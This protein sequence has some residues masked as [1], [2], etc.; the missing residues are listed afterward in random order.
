M[1][2][3]KVLQ[4]SKTSELELEDSDV[5]IL[6]RLGKELSGKKDFWGAPEKANESDYASVVQISS[7]SL[8]QSWEVTVVNSIGVLGL[9]KDSILV[10]PKIPLNHFLFIAS[11]SSLFGRIDAT[12]SQIGNNWNIIAVLFDSFVRQVER[13]LSGREFLDYV[14]TTELRSSPRG[15]ILITSTYEN[16]LR[17]KAQIACNFDDLGRDNSI[18]R[19]VAAALRTISGAN[20]TSWDLRRKASSL[21]SNFPS[22]PHN[23]SDYSAVLR[24]VPIH[25]KSLVQLA[26][27]IISSQVGDFDGNQKRST[28]FLIPTPPLIETGI[29]NLL[30]QNLPPDIQMS[31]RA[32]RKLLAPSRIS[33]NPDLLLKLANGSETLTEIVT[34]DVKYSLTDKDWDRKHLYQAVAFAAAFRAKRGIVVSF[35]DKSNKGTEELAVGDVLIRRFTW[36]TGLSSPEHS[37]TQ[38]VQEITDW[39]SSRSVVYSGTRS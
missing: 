29:R 15:R 38:L 26:K 24:D 4:E 30:R 11:A 33:V 32:A 18:N 31:D 17:G 3:G 10:R 7:T 34:G 21:L 13:V 2:S 27:I 37:L 1:R 23:L 20:Q 14:D 25:F 19:L 9:P 6:R 28:T 12:P 8:P 5:A 16:L 35:S 36:N 22:T 39:L